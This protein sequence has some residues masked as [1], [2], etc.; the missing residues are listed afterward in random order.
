MCVKTR[1]KRDLK[2]IDAINATKIINRFT[3][4]INIDKQLEIP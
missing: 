3:A 1:F 4:V 2:I